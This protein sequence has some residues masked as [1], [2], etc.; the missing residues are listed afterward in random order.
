MSGF[1]KT[2]FGGGSFLFRALTPFLVTGGLILLVT[3]EEPDAWRL[4]VV[5]LAE[6]S[7]VLLIVALYDPPR[8]KWASRGL[9]GIV[10]VAFLAYFVDE[11]LAVGTMG[12]LSASRAEASPLNAF[13]GLVFIGGPCLVHTV[14]GSFFRRRNRGEGASPDDPCNPL[15]P[16]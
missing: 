6:A 9:T 1:G 7:I 10:F 13:L 15:S 16:S 4:F 3:L 11:L 14:C 5:A 2:L 8:Y 12:P